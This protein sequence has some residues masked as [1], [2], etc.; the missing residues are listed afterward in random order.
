MPEVFHNKG[1]SIRELQETDVDKVTQLHIDELPSDFLAILGQSFLKRYYYPFLFKNCDLGLGVEDQ[2][3]II[4]YVV[5]CSDED[6]LRKFVKKH[7]WVLSAACLKH[8]LSPRFI[9]YII[10]IFFLL[11]FHSEKLKGHELCYIAVSSSQH[12][13]GLGS[14]LVKQAHEKLKSRG[15]LHGWVKTLVSTPRTIKFYERL[16]YK[17]AATKLGRAY[18]S[19]ELNS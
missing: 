11:G 6:F 10:E 13:K 15:L 7:F 1:I 12:D 4:G 5:F 3:G 9:R 2:S 19:I 14:L 18:L 16:N 8:S 17:L